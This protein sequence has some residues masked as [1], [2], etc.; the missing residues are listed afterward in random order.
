[1]AQ[2]REELALALNKNILDGEQIENAGRLAR[3]AEA[4]L[5]ALAEL[6]DMSIQSASWRFPLPLPMS[7]EQ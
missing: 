5:A 7:V 1:V 6:D 2:G 4:A 3:Y